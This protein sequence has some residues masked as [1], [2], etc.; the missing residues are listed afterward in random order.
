MNAAKNRRQFALAFLLVSTP[1][2]WVPLERIAAVASTEVAGRIVRRD[3]RGERVVVIRCE[4]E[5]VAGHDVLRESV[6]HA[7]GSIESRIE[8]DRLA[9]YQGAK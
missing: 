5:I 4:I 2:S 3:D 9:P 1:Y 8:V 6:L 7:D